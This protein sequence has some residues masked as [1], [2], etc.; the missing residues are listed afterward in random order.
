M[1]FVERA[2]KT[3]IGLPDRHMNES[4]IALAR[5]R[6][7][8][9]IG[10]GSV[11]QTALPLMV[12]TLALTQSQITIIAPEASLVGD[13]AILGQHNCMALRQ[14][15]FYACLAPILRAGDVVLNLATDVNSCALIQLT[16]SLDALYLDTVI[17][18]WGNWY[19][20]ADRTPDQRTNYV[21]REEALR[22]KGRATA[23]LT[24]GANPGLVSHFAK[25]ALIDVAKKTGLHVHP[26]NRKEWAALACSLDLRLIQIAEYDSQQSIRVRQTDQFLN[27]WSVAGFLAEACQPAE[28]GWGTHEK[29]WPVDGRRHLNGC[30]AAIYLNRPGASVRV[31]S[32]VPDI[33]PYHGFLVTHGESISLADYLTVRDNNNTPTYRPS[34]HYAYRPCDSAVASLHDLA[35]RHWDKT[36][37]SQHVLM[38]DIVSGSDTLGVLLGY[39]ERGCYWYGS[40]MSVGQARSLI[41]GANATTMQVAAGV[42][43]GLVWAME[44]PHCGVVEPE[45][46]DSERVLE[47][48]RPWLGEMLGEFTDWN[49][50]ASA[51]TLFAQGEPKDLADTDPWQFFRVRVD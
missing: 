10:F 33:G 6:H 48:A 25:L 22:I 18:P 2:S 26:A 1:A 46:M 3:A 42:L 12:K 37:M 34:V 19:A 49:P 7:F 32:W 47:I 15:N 4:L 30:G 39:G 5:G 17:E 20:N 31:K 35:G 24:H 44:N 29:D 41:P 27:T 9:V 45:D 16:Q 14:D 51:S 23:V 36:G 40:R 11:A 43:S 50:L 13:A 38:D 8:Y 21:L 28:L